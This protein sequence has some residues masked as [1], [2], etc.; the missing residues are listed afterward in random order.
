MQV[1]NTWTTF[2][3]A[4][5]T[6]GW[7]T[8]LLKSISIRQTLSTWNNAFIKVTRKGVLFI[9]IVI[10]IFTKNTHIN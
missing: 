2:D 4:E 10:I 1:I 5:F 7:V 3:R 9:V 8:E 6:A